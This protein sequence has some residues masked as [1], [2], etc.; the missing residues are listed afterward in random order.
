MTAASF[1]WNR[2]QKRHGCGI[3]NTINLHQ[4]W[5]RDRP[6]EALQPAFCVVRIPAVKDR[7][8]RSEIVF[9]DRFPVFRWKRFCF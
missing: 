8:M 4:E 6:Y 7:K 5:R 1:F 9:Y 3:V 2:L